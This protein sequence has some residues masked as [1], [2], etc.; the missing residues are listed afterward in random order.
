LSS[1]RIVAVGLLTQIDL[2][3]LGSTFRRVFPVDDTPTFGGLLQAIDEADRD[4]WR[5]RDRLDQE[6]RTTRCLE[7]SDQQRTGGN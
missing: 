3:T 6:S 2:E 7:P 5:E 1:D 4:I